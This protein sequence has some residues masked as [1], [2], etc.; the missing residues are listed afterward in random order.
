M[1]IFQKQ[2]KTLVSKPKP[3]KSKW[4][5]QGKKLQKALVKWHRSHQDQETNHYGVAM[6]NTC[7]SC[8]VC[9]SPTL[10]QI[11]AAQHIKMM[12]SLSHNSI[13]NI[14][15]S[16]HLKPHYLTP[17][18]NPLLNSVKL[19]SQADLLSCQT[20]ANGL[21]ECRDMTIMKLMCGKEQSR[22]KTSDKFSSRRFKVTEVHWLSGF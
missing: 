7:F 10:S 17:Q 14:T 1:L 15:M 12:H 19:C 16:L 22:T 13:R 5:P 11:L 6:K 2:Q 3:W 20:M 9:C 4:Y 18:N 8:C 21:H